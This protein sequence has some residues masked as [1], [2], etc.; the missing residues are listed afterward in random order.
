MNTLQ[1]ATFYCIKMGFQPVAYR[2]LET[3]SRRI[4][5]HVV[6]QNKIRLIFQSPYDPGHSGKDRK[7]HPGSR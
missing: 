3:G 6:E 2:G 1:A 7:K 5:E 4:V